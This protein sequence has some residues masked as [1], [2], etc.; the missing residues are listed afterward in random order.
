MSFI[1]KKIF[2]FVILISI[3]SVLCVNFYESY[4]MHPNFLTEGLNSSEV[5][6]AFTTSGKVVNQ[7]HYGFDITDDNNVLVHVLSSNKPQIGDQ[8]EI[9]GVLEPSGY[10]KSIKVVK[11]SKLGNESLYLR[12]LLGL[13]LVIIIFLRYW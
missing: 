7:S 13:I 12:S 11:I 8:V 6:G 10:F 2:I 9:L 1:F 3:L 4:Q 5:Q